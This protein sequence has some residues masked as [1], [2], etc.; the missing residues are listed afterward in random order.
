MMDWRV[1]VGFDEKQCSTCGEI[2]ALG[3]FHGQERGRK[4]VKAACKVCTNRS[5]RIRSARKLSISPLK[6]F[7]VGGIGDNRFYSDQ[8]YVNF[9]YGETARAE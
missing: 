7:D 9:Y 6:P 5:Q 2:K 1:S 8:E 3:D 4:G